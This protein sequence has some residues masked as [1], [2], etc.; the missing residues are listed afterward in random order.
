MAAAFSSCTPVVSN[1]ANVV[2]LV[3]GAF[4]LH[5]EVRWQRKVLKTVRLD[6]VVGPTSISTCTSES[7][8][9]CSAAAEAPM[10]GDGGIALCAAS[11]PL[12]W[13]S[14]YGASQRAHS[15][16]NCERTN[17]QSERAPVSSGRQQM[18]KGANR[19]AYD[20]ACTVCQRSE[21]APVVNQQV[22]W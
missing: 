15:K 5:Q 11:R 13:I 18:V 17:W 21:K 22:R 4:S 9:Q 7:R 19:W 12:V 3:R 14:K 2:R 6:N 10:S 1:Y 8:R 20:D 16:R